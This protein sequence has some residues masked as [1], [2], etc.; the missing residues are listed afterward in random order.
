MAPMNQVFHMSLRQPALDLAILGRLAHGPS[1]G[2]ELRKH[3]SMVN[4]YQHKVSFGSIYPALRRLLNRGL[5]CDCGA[6]RPRLVGGRSRRT[7]HITSAGEEYLSSQLST[8]DPAAWADDFGVRFSLLGMTDWATRLRILRDRR[9]H[10]A[11]H[12][13]VLEQATPSWLDRY[14]TELVR[15]ARDVVANEIV[16]LDQMIAVEESATDKETR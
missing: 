4:T 15:R 2:Y 13:A 14:S 9:D 11:S 8:A 10:A 12:L 1:H 5:I 16:W 6:G 7:Y 3:V